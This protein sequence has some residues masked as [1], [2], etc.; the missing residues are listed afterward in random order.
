MP[1]PQNHHTKSRTTKQG[2]HKITRNASNTCN[3][4]G[5]RMGT[6]KHWYMKSSSCCLIKLCETWTTALQNSNEFMNDVSLG[7]SATSSGVMRYQSLD[8]TSNEF[9]S[10]EYRPPSPVT[11]NGHMDEYCAMYVPTLEFF[12]DS[13]MHNRRASRAWWPSD[14]SRCTYGM[15]SEKMMKLRN[16]I[17]MWFKRRIARCIG[18]FIRYLLCRIAAVTLLRWWKKEQI[19]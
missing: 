2:D 19:Q 16:E 14:P 4:A 9:G 15:S 6:M 1:P 12:C 8:S 3:K 18:A 5:P 11:N 7:I 10:D 13:A 17:E